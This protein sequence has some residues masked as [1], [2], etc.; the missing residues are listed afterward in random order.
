M[1]KALS[2]LVAPLMLVALFAGCSGGTNGSGASE[3]DGQSSQ[4]G[5]ESSSEESR[6]AGDAGYVNLDS[7]LPVVNE[8]IS[9]SIMVLA[10]AVSKEPE[11]MWF[12]QYYQEQTGI[13]FEFNAI[14]SSD[15]NEKK[16]VLITAGDYSD[17][18]WGCGFTNAEILEYGTDGIFIPLNDLIYEYGDNIVAI[19]D[20]KDV[21]ASITTPDG[22]IYSLGTA[23]LSNYYTGVICTI[24]EKWLE[25]VGIERPTTIEE[26]YNALAAFMDGD[27]NGDGNPANEIPLSGH[28]DNLNGL[29]AMV[30]NMFG[31]STD[32]SHIGIDGL[33]G[34]VVYIPLEARYK[35]YLTF[36]HRLYEEGLLDQDVYVQDET[37]FQAKTSASLVGCFNGVPQYNDPENFMDYNEYAIAYDSQ[38]E[39][40]LYKNRGVNSG[41]FQITDTCEYPEAAMRFINLFYDPVYAFDIMYGPN[42][43]EWPDGTLEYRAYNVT[44]DP[45]IGVHVLV[46]ENGDYQKLRQPNWDDSELTLWEYYA[47]DHPVPGCAFPIDDTYF[48]NQLFQGRAKDETE[49][50]AKYQAQVDAVEYNDITVADHYW[51]IQNLTWCTEH[52][53]YGYPNVF[54]NDEQQKFIDENDTIL[55]DYIST[56]EAAFVTGDKDIE[57]EYDAFVQELKRLG[58][59][60]LRQIYIDAY[61]AE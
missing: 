46:D 25:N 4:S 7:D 45:G 9:M 38:S 42:I 47:V 40:V 56:M 37:Q 43:V 26:F 30:L 3:E 27:A 32:G 1:K 20:E 53:V 57:A 31:Y 19:Y 18:I 34:D 15:W 28:K 59:E 52:I 10:D 33:T 55:S 58:A 41:Y 2:L 44:E 23:S 51:K 48:L 12:W 36:M 21:W 17:I 39:P 22:S 6:E 60:E 5:E 29:R 49:Q 14:L 24:N 35:E 8:P 13:D 11:E 54:L 50:I 16:Q 61:P